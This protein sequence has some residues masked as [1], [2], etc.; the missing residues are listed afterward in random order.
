[1]ELLIFEPD[2]MSEIAITSTL[3][4]DDW[5]TFVNEHP[6]GNIFHTPEM[7]HVFERAKKHKPELWAATSNGEILA[8]LLP[9]RIVLMNRLLSPLTTRSVSYGSILYTHSPIGEAGL[10]KLLSTYTREVSGPLL[11]TELRH[12]TDQQAAQAAL[13]HAGFCYEDNL[14]YLIDLNRPAEEIF[15]NMGP[16]TRK[17]LRHALNNKEVTVEEITERSEIK[18]V[19]NLLK[20][21]YLAAQVPLA[22]FSLFEAAFDI[23][24]PL[25]M[26]R[27]TVARV[28]D[29]PASVSVDLY[30]KKT[31][32]GWFGGTDR[33]YAAYVPNEILT[34]HL[35]EWGANH[36]YHV[37]DFGGAGRPEE[38]YSVRTFK[39]KFG[40]T[41]VNY[42]RNVYIH[43]PLLMN[44]SK[45]GYRLTRGLF[46]G[47]S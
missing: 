17:T 13:T 33:A 24:Y 14:N 7:F 16:R 42:G 35:L 26:V 34:W 8:M 28:K 29:A 36:G 44:V 25:G 46:F 40:G 21:T 1:M 6:E 5:R 38:E 41:L 32:Y 39:S 30:Y 18:T 15:K 45:I 47:G 23:L 3:S 2:N 4:E 19:Y 10:S 31:I 27:F 12:L 37:Y 11:F 20:S 22:D 43:S 9:V